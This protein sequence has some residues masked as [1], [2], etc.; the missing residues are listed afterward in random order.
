MINQCAHYTTPFISLQKDSE[1]IMESWVLMEGVS[2]FMNP[3]FFFG[4]KAQMDLLETFI[5]G[6]ADTFFKV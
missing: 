3:T 1:G 4:I 5:P 6:L 2:I